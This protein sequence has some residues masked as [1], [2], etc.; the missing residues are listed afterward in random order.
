VNDRKNSTYGVRKTPLTSLSENQVSAHNIK[1]KEESSHR[2][3]SN[4]TSLTAEKNN[5]RDRTRLSEDRAFRRFAISNI[6]AISE[7]RIRVNSARRGTP[8][9]DNNISG[10]IVNRKSSGQELL[11]HARPSRSR[12]KSFIDTEID[13]QDIIISDHKSR[14]HLP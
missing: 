11:K 3:R 10:V 2:V 8:S 13:L 9:G 6:I 14:P 7:N 5:K 4:K 1:S 12:Q